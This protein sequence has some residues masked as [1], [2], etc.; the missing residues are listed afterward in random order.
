MKTYI[1][2]YMKELFHQVTDVSI[3]RLM[4]NERKLDKLM[5]GYSYI[6]G[7][8]MMLLTQVNITFVES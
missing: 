1:S 8:A 5:F 4:E 7:S 6:T 3:L 2:L